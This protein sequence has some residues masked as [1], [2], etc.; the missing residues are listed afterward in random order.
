MSGRSHTHN[1]RQHAQHGPHPYHVRYQTIPYPQLQQQDPDL[2]PRTDADK[3]SPYDFCFRT[4]HT[5]MMNSFTNCSQA[6]KLSSQL[7]I[8]M[9]KNIIL[10]VIL[11]LVGKA[12]QQIPVYDTV[13]RQVKFSLVFYDID[14]FFLV[15]LG[16]H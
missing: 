15:F 9:H 13:P 10:L 8:N 5:A 4:S 2:R 3:S 11:F 7:N 6:S 14:V 1:L 16:V 12:T